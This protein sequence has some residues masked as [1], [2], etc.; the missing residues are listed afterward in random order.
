MLERY[1]I[2]LET[3][4]TYG[5][6]LLNIGAQVGSQQVCK[7]MISKGANINT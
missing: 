1:M 4:D 3:K 5:N 2:D 6:T 7:Y